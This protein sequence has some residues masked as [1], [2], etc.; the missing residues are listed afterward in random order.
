M[1][2]TE[3]AAQIHGQITRA[4]QEW[5]ATADSLPELVCLVNLEGRILR[6]NRTIERWGLGK[7]HEIKGNLLHPLFHPDC[8][9]SNCLLADFLYEAWKNLHQGKTSD[10]EL[11]DSVLKRYI[12]LQVCPI[13]D[14][15]SGKATLSESFAVM[16]IHD[17]TR[18]KELESKLREANQA[19]E[20]A[21]RQAEKKAKEAEMANRAK[22]TFLA[23]M[24]HDIRTPMNGVIGILEL[25]LDTSLSPEQWEFFNIIQSSSQTLLKLL[26]DI[27]DFSKIEAG[28]IEL[29]HNPFDLERTIMTVAGTMAS[30]AYNKG[31]EFF[32]E[33]EPDVPHYLIGDSLRLQ[34]IIMNL[35][36]NAIKFTDKGEILLQITRHIS[37]QADE[38]DEIVLRF[39]VSDTG[40]GISEEKQQG[41]F[42]AF[43][44][45]DNS[46]SRR[47]GGT[48]LGL[49]IA[50]NLVE[51]MGGYLWVESQVGHGSL[52]QFSANFTR[53]LSIGSH[54]DQQIPAQVGMSRVDTLLVDDNPTHRRILRRL[55]ENWGLQV[56]EA[57]NGVEGLNALHAVEAHEYQ[58]VL[59]DSKMPEM[60][61]FEMLSAL[62]EKPTSAKSILML[63]NSTEYHQ[64]RDRYKKLAV[65]SC[66][67]KPIDPSRLFEII[68]KV[69]CGESEAYDV[70]ESI[71]QKSSAFPSAEQLPNLHIL[72]AEDHAVNQLVIKKWLERWNWKTTLVDNGEDVLDAVEHQDFDLILMDVQMPEIDGVTATKKLRERERRT[73]RHIPIIALTAHAM[74][75]DRERF[76]EAGMD[77]YV[78]KPLQSG[79]L[80]AAIERC[81]QEVRAVNRDSPGENLS[82]REQNPIIDVE[83]LLLSFD[84]DG[85]FTKEL[86][87]TYFKQSAP[88]LLHSLRQAVETQ[89]PTLL[90][91]AAHRLKGA[92]GMIGATQVYVE[93]CVLEELG[94]EKKLSGAADVLKALEQKLQELEQFIE[95]HITQYIPNF[96]ELGDSDE[97]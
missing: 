55:L 42:E 91:Q 67:A 89:N 68:L 31:V 44:Q 63:S 73:G 78:S 29:E 46:I 40:I 80:Y 88:E 51:L 70:P 39:S 87:L 76:I 23:A 5:E 64:Q 28:H 86:L 81:M 22:S 35:V 11:R 27:L 34:E 72:V 83:E 20:E 6:A 17:I 60:D 41:I 18:R 97:K 30:R 90:E 53:N 74:E 33:I 36:G 71:E 24:S 93:T 84:N 9:A 75:G 26:N 48:G 95:T 14:F 43:T 13:S 56:T 45:A 37:S 79:R 38:S 47:F 49:A 50:R 25:L 1:S 16:I 85:D 96:F 10:L 15:S 58:L 94:R 57:Q 52:F 66:I 77:A 7:V 82:R 54:P 92:S 12:H 65:N 32:W 8:T 2:D 62:V 4:K 69:L 59:L 61:G 21:R 3:T 19:L